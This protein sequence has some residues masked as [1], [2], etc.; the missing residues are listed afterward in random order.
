MLMSFE[1]G[2]QTPPIAFFGIGAFIKLVYLI[3]LPYPEKTKKEGIVPLFL[4][5]LFFFL[6]YVLC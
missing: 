5:G 1:T 4:S 3:P 6:A 2:I